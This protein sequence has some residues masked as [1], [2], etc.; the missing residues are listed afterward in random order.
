MLRACFGNH[1]TV[2]ND[3]RIE[4]PVSVRDR[5]ETFERPLA[6]LGRVA[7][8]Q[9]P[10]SMSFSKPTCNGRDC[11]IPV[12]ISTRFTTFKSLPVGWLSGWHTNQYSITH[13]HVDLNWIKL[14]DWIKLNLRWMTVLRA[15]IWIGS[16]LNQVR[17][18]WISTGF[19]LSVRC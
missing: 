10:N 7:K 13:I 12:F 3:H 18:G 9:L 15:S 16:D 5:Q 8:K 19:L 14:A 6:L 2:I 4:Q 17:D 1:S 11:A